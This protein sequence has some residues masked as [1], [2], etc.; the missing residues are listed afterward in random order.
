MIEV[1]VGHQRA[2][3]TRFFCD[4]E[5][6]RVL[7][8]GYGK[9]HDVASRLFQTLNLVKTSRKIVRGS[10]GHGLDGDGIFPADL[11]PSGCDGSCYFHVS[12]SFVMSFVFNQNRAAMSLKAMTTIRIISTTSPAKCT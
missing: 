1:D 6:F 3:H 2:L 4:C 7:F 9:A 10:I 12:Q 11:H 8:L 5:N